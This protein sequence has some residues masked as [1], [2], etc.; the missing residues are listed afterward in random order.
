LICKQWQFS[1]SSSSSSSSE[2]EE[3]ETRRN[4]RDL[5]DIAL[6]NGVP[7]FKKQFFENCDWIWKKLQN[8][9][10]REIVQ[11]VWISSVCELSDVFQSVIILSRFSHFL[12]AVFSASASISQS[13]VCVQDKGFYFLFFFFPFH[14]SAFVFQYLELGFVA[15][16]IAGNAGMEVAELFDPS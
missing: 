8:P 13:G 7:S 16:G 12:D 2:E 5:V 11:K 10:L 9:N 6:L 15:V 1:S 14:F 4:S 3:E